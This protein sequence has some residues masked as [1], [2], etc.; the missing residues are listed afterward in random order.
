M[1]PIK[2]SKDIEA[3]R[4][5]GHKLGDI[6]AKLMTLSVPGVTLSEIEKKA[7]DMIHEAGGVPS[8]STVED[9][10][11]AT[12]LCLNEQVVHGIPN[13][14][15]LK[16]G[17]VFT[18]DIG[19]IYKGFH[20]DTARSLIVGNGK[21]EKKERLLQVGRETLEKAIAVARPGNHI[22]DI[23][24]VIET[25]I[26]G[27]GYSIVESL[28]GHG[29]GRKLHELP[30]IPGYIKGDIAKTPTIAVGMTLAIEIIYAEGNG[31]IWYTNDDGWT[32]ETKDK[33]LTAVFEH[34]IAVT[35]SENL[36]LTRSE[37]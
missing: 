25:N 26:K 1:I 24:K 19:M 30:Q 17:D 29:V 35:E 18:I 27:A 7:V 37:L 33:S 22:G 15:V 10:K 4:E 6:L 13:K 21:D 12:C 8:F 9:Y 5:G 31:E 32:L 20:T 36:V 34:S 14:R 16:A 3:M 2:S 23:S 28:T 11:W